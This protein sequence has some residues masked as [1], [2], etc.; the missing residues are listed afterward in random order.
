MMAD[1]MAALLTEMKMDSA[2]VIGWSDGGING[3]LLA[4][5]HP[6]KVRKLA[7]TGANLWPDTTAIF[8][9][10]IDMVQPQYRYLKNMTS[11][12]TES[13]TGWKLVRLLLEERHISV[14]QLQ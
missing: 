8:P 10:V 7:I 3:L 6:E 1:D 12:N 11:R 9:E 4:I 2:Y 14:S 5:R 13:K